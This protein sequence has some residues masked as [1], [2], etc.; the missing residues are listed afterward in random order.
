MKR[1]H[2][3]ANVLLWIS[4]AL[5]TACAAG[6]L[7]EES[8]DL[9]AE[10][11]AASAALAA[12]G[13]G[14]CLDGDTSFG[15]AGPF[16]VS[17]RTVGRV[18]F[19]VPRVPTGC[20]VP[21]VHLANGTGATCSAY[22]SS[23]QRLATHGFLAACYENTNTGAGQFGLEAYE[24]AIRE[25]PIADATKFGSTGHSQGG[26]ASLVTIAL[27]QDKYGE[28]VQT[29]ALP[30]QP[31]SGFGVQPR[32]QSW[33]QAYRKVR[34]P[35]FMFSGNSTTGYA[36]S[37]L[38]GIGIGDGLVAISWVNEGFDALSRD[39]EAYHWTAVGSTHIP[40]PQAAENEIAPAW[41]RW[42][43]LGDQ[44]ACRYV[45]GLVS[46]RWRVQKQQNVQDC[47]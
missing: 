45:K 34:S 36:N 38:L 31:A 1:G 18:K 44:A 4:S 30:M 27:I 8:D 28:E 20:K 32:G 19:W 46:G 5:T 37:L 21:I 47:Q 16:G 12:V 3:T 14:S 17:T 7:P 6:G 29:A 41:F 13:T 25:F 22:G 43:L 40:T 10:E 2:L 11:A 33:Q 42:K 35:V 24:T 15:G 39:I 23:L 9:A 26:Q